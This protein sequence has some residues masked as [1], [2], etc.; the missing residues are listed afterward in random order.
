MHVC[1]CHSGMPQPAVQIL[2]C[3]NGIL[4]I[5]KVA[6]VCHPLQLRG[7]SLP[8]LVNKFATAEVH[9]KSISELYYLYRHAREQVQACMHTL[10]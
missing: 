3:L 4:P 2:G 7:V 6:M 8:W 5:C 10:T 9:S 1:R